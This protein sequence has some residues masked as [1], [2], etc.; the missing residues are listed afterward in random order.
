MQQK[1]QYLH[2]LLRE[3]QEPFQLNTYIADR[4]CENRR[5]P[6]PPKTSVQLKKCS[7][8]KRSLCKHA[9]F[10]SFQD[11]SSPDVRK[12]PLAFPS[13][14]SA[15]RTPNGRVRLNVPARTA[16]LLLDAA[17]RIQKQQQQGEKK[18]RPQI[19]L[20]LFGSIL[21]RLKDRNRNKK[22]EIKNATDQR[23]D[24]D[25]V[26]NEGV[27]VKKGNG[28]DESLGVSYSRLSS[29]G[30]SESNEEKSLDLETSSSCRSE[31]IDE[32]RIFCSSPLSPFRFSLE[33]C[34]SSGRRTPEFSSPAASPNLCRRQDKE[35]YENGEMENG[36]Q[37]EEDEKEQCSPVSVL[38]PP[39]EDDGVEEEDD[40]GH[41]DSDLECSYAIVQRAQ[42][43]LLYK[44]RRFEKLAE[45]D[46][47]ELEKIMLEEEEEDYEDNAAECDGVAECVDHESFSSSRGDDD[48][49]IEGFASNGIIPL[50][51]K[52]LVSDLISEEK[53]ETNRE[54][55]WGRVCKRLDSWKEA[56]SET[57]DMMV[58]LD[59]R[60]ASCEWKSLR[61]QV[62]E[63]AMEIEV[64]IFGSLVDEFSGEL[65]NKILT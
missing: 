41:D 55:V 2:E 60:T 57:I 22:R 3:E 34:E 53:T 61:E 27:E 46:P 6:P 56:K 21:K 32:E 47:I 11:S 48:E 42:Q 51:I 15:S 40:E 7:A 20:G 35:N 36:E 30:W 65:M 17:L 37:E 14:L 45:L 18:A 63:T 12:S 13:P 43:Q 16:A 28:G 54:V 19:G 52:R 33:R 24:D 5:L 25:N 62:E 38:D 23:K 26:V 50:E 44:L 8:T 4:R 59:L 10:F 64:G 29:A 58:E 31:E 49:D 9:C 1:K 39:F